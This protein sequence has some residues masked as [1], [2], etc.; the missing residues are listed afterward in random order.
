MVRAPVQSW[1]GIS[2]NHR[3]LALVVALGYRIAMIRPDTDIALAHR[4]AEAA[5]E[6]IRPFFRARFEIETKGDSSPVTQADR[7]A[8]A[9]MR[10]HLDTVV[11]TY[12]QIREQAD[13]A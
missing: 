11:E 12:W 13:Q 1:G 3:S 8:E 4:L 9:A 7:A 6:A 5:G 10:A 2:G